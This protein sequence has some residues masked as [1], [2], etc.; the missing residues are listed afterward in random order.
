MDDFDDY[1][2]S[3]S[4]EAEKAVDVVKFG[5]KSIFVSKNLENSDKIAYLNITTLEDLSFCVR[6]TIKGYQ[7]VSNQHDVDDENFN[8]KHELCAETIDAL[9]GLISPLYVQ[10]FSEKLT[11]K[12][13]CLEE[14]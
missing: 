12:L 5:V 9:V 8:E 3:L 7:V 1:S 6:L 14:E 4:D 10:K 13:R 2:H 11:D